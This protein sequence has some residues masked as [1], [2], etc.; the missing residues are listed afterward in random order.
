MKL[1][2]FERV[3]DTHVYF[4]RGPLSQWYTSEFV[5]PV[6][7]EYISNFNAKR[8]TYSNCEQY[9][10][11][12]KAMMMNDTDIANEIMSIK[13]PKAIK[14]LG[15]KIKNFDAA[16]WDKYKF[17]LVTFGNRCKFS[18]SKEFMDFLRQTGDRTI[19]EAAWYDKVWG[20]GLAQ[21]NDDI[22]DENTWLGENLLGKALMAVRD[23][24][25]HHH[26][27]VY[28]SK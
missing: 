22:L 4:V 20:V 16:L 27:D 15:R 21:D 18:H 7:L 12:N 23:R 8:Y 3:T 5:A 11:H 9:M 6:Y 17:D 1:G 25:F 10:M 24:K 14:D 13:N 2:E 28:Y 26:G 19:V